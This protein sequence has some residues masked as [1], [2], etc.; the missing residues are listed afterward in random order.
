LSPTARHEVVHGKRG[1]VVFKATVTADAAAVTR[2]DNSATTW[3][4]YSWVGCTVR[5][6]RYARTPNSAADAWVWYCTATGHEVVYSES[7]TIVLNTTDAR[8]TAAVTWV[9]YRSRTG[10]AACA[11]A[12][13]ADTS[14]GVD[15]T[16][17]QAGSGWIRVTAD[18]R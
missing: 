14:T 10:V 2:I 13:S 7:I 11:R 6:S 1:A 5:S 4:V 8:I 12:V 18:R 9:R 3:S 15:P 16:T 17:R